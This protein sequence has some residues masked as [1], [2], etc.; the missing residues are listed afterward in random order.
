MPV[1]IEADEPLIRHTETGYL[2]HPPACGSTVD[3]G[4]CVGIGLRMVDRAR[5]RRDLRELV[6]KDLPEAIGAGFDGLDS[7]DTDGSHLQGAFRWRA[8]QEPIG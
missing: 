4:R 1:G 8:S 5:P 6:G 7:F 3:T 2:A